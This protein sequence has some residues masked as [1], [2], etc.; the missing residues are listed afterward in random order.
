MAATIILRLP[1]LWLFAFFGKIDLS[2]KRTLSSFSI[3]FLRNHTAVRGM[4]TN[5]ATRSPPGF[6]LGSRFH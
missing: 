4:L 1:N 6:M 3:F 2:R 5:L